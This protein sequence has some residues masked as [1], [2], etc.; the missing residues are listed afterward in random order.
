L[1]APDVGSPRIAVVIPCFN[2][3]GTLADAVSSV[4][5][6]EPCELVVV[7]DGSTDP[8]TRRELAV[9]ERNGVDV[10]SQRN[11]G[12][13]AARM[14]G[15]RRTNARYVFPLDADDVL[16]PGTLAVLAD[17]LDRDPVAVAAWGN[18]VTFGIASVV[19]ETA[20]ELD[21]W[22]ITYVNELPASSLFRRAALEAVG[23]W[24]NTGEYEDWELWMALAE[25]GLHG[26]HV[27]QV[28]YRHRLHGDRRQRRARARHAAHYA[29]MARRHGELFRARSENRRTSR[30]RWRKVLFPVI[31]RL[32]LH[33]YDRYRLCSYVAQPR[34][35]LTFRADALRRVL[36]RRG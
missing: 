12:P 7:D 10:L 28:V 21:P 3:G 11:A 6:Q 19:Y 8:E 14:A 26:I 33:G 32:P 31:M 24:P 13:S 1:S 25:R 20:E 15:V 22:A 2:D 30:A 17:A 34:Q 35:T 4:R 18:Y 16:L 9:L 27:P 36:L 23:G 29:T 5:A